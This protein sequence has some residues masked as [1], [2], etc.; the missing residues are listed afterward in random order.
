[1]GK[2]AHIQTIYSQPCNCLITIPQRPLLVVSDTWLSFAAQ[3]VLRSTVSGRWL[4]IQGMCSSPAS[5]QTHIQ[6]T[7][8]ISMP[9]GPGL[10]CRAYIKA[11]LHRN[12]AMGPQNLV[13]MTYVC[14]NKRAY[15]ASLL[16][17][18]LLCTQENCINKQDLSASPVKAPPVSWA[19]GTLQ[20]HC[21]VQGR[22]NSDPNARSVTIMIT[23]AC[24]GCE[25]DHLDIQALTFNK[26]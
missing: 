25:P 16:Y 12:I 8:C 23:D 15:K 7:R 1:M 18:V 26:A 3:G 20:S 9:L 10:T 6:Q 14:L 17:I 21:D 22:C 24:P 19:L 11:N 2:P 5:F 13:L 4:R